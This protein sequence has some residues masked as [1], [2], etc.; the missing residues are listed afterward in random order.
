MNALDEYS[1]TAQAPHHIFDEDFHREAL[2]RGRGINKH[3]Q[4]RRVHSLEFSE[5]YSKFIV[6]SNWGIQKLI[7]CTPETGH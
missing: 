6:S 7:L 1:T 3:S 5:I 4:F 2:T